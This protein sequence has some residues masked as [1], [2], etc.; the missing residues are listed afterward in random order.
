MF[1]HIEFVTVCH[2]IYKFYKSLS[3]SLSF[4][5]IVKT[6]YKKK[7]S[8]ALKFCVAEIKRTSKSYFKYKSRHRD[9]SRSFKALV[10]ERHLTL[11]C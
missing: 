11:P 7:Y 4:H 6:F 9:F 3:Q 5:H 2:Q 10:I 1:W 8:Q